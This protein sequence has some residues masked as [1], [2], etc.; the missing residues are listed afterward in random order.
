MP[1][2]SPS[3]GALPSK[4]EP[5]LLLCRSRRKY[6]NSCVCTRRGARTV[7]AR[8]EADLASLGDCAA[9]A[10]RGRVR[11]GL[12]Y[13]CRSARRSPYSA[14][15][16]AFVSL[17]D[18]TVRTGCSDHN[19]DRSLQREDSAICELPTCPLLKRN[20]RDLQP[21]RRRPNN[22]CLPAICEYCGL[23]IF[24]QLVSSGV[25]SPSFRFATI[26]SRSDSQTRR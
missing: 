12:G 18:S 19:R 11:A 10:D 6:R 4:N 14:A 17:P 8:S 9:A 5:S 3:C 2:L 26:P 15:T 25:Y 16:H 23:R 20:A 24:T 22:S 13:G 7:G 1:V 21:A